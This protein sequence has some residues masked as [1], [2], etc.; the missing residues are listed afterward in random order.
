VVIIADCLSVDGSSILPRVAKIN[1]SMSAPFI[2]SD[3]KFSQESLDWIKATFEFVKDKNEGHDLFKTEFSERKLGRK[4]SFE[5]SLALEEIKNYLKKFGIDDSYFD[6]L[7]GPDIFFSNK[8]HPSPHFP[9]FDLLR[10]IG[11]VKSRF[12]VC[13]IYGLNDDMFWWEDVVPGHPLVMPDYRQQIGL[14]GTTSQERLSYLGNPTSIAENMYN[15][16]CSAFVRTDCAH[17]ITIKNP[18]VRLV[19][20]VALNKSID[21]LRKFLS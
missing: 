3:F 4:V 18:G 20:T 16:T 12:N 9:H 7:T 1:I 14:K 13:V 5:G 8:P 19:V 15:D 11:L 10:K 17:S 6:D 21:E 2:K